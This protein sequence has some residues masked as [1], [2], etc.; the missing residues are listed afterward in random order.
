MSVADAAAVLRRGA[1]TQW[2]PAVVEAAVAA[3]EQP[4]VMPAGQPA[5]IPA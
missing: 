3:L 1:G 2:N 5:T 4:R